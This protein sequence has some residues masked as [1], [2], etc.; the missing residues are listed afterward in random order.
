[1]RSEQDLPRLP[2]PARTEGED[3]AHEN[4]TGPVIGIAQRD[5]DFSQCDKPDKGQGAIF[6]WSAHAVTASCENIWSLSGV[7]EQPET[8]I[9]RHEKW[10]EPDIRV[11]HKGIFEI[12]FKESG[13]KVPAFDMRFP[14]HKRQS[15]DADEHNDQLKK[16]RRASCHP[17][18]SI[19]DAGRGSGLTKFGSSF[20][21]I[22]LPSMITILML[23]TALMSASGSP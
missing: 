3:G 18:G 15:A 6:L 12:D 5:K 10:R 4:A 23:R 2:S 14:Q 17:Y 21:S 9:K 7:P 11:G 13:M 16:Q 19:A 8:L 20:V 1:M 22:T